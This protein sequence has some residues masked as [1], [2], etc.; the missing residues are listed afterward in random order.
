MR[1]EAKEGEEKG[2]PRGLPRR[3]SEPSNREGEGDGAL[4]VSTLLM[5]SREGGEG[6][7]ARE[8]LSRACI[9]NTEGDRAASH[10][11]RSE[12]ARRS[13]ASEETIER[14]EREARASPPFC[15]NPSQSGRSSSRSE[16]KASSVAE[17]SHLASSSSTRGRPEEARPSS[18]ARS[19]RRAR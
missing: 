19:R 16:R 17:G 12:R 10:E 3:S 4:S 18:S 15:H 8:R 7:E 11:K 14:K 6:R 1:R 9:D 5:G 13:L 2:R